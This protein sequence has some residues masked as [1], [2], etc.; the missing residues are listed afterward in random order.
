MTSSEG[1]PATVHT[2]AHQLRL[3]T[4]MLQSVND[5]PFSP[6]KARL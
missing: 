2:N 4:V 6:N 3:S 5:Q 1:V